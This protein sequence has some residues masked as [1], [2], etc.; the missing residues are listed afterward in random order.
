MFEY[1]LK[2]YV[3]FCSILSSIANIGLLGLGIYGITVFWPNY[4][5]QKRIENQ[6]AAALNALFQLEEFEDSLLQLFKITKL[7]RSHENHL[8]AQN[9]ALT[10]LKT[11]RNRLLLL[12]RDPSIKDKLFWLQELIKKFHP[13]YE[14][15]PSFVS[16]TILSEID[17]IYH[18]KKELDLN[19]L[20]EI[21]VALVAI[22]EISDLDGVIA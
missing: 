21:R 3:D 1:A 13:R 6:G 9:D 15:V 18:E 17:A 8:P 14:L 19:K 2:I 22:Y 16:S 20:E 12:R 5:R 7:A 4:K 11:L 10:K